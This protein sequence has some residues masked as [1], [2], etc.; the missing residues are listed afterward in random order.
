MNLTLPYLELWHKQGI[1]QADVLSCGEDK[2][3]FG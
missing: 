2:D 3:D 1:N